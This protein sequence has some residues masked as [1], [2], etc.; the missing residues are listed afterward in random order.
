MASTGQVIAVNNGEYCGSIGDLND[1]FWRPSL[2][3]LGGETALLY[4]NH[5]GGD[6]TPTIA[7]LKY[8]TDNDKTWSWFGATPLVTLPDTGVPL[9][10]Y[11]FRWSPYGGVTKVGDERRLYVFYGV[12]LWE[13]YTE[14]SIDRWYLLDKGPVVNSGTLPEIKPTVF[15]QVSAGE[16]HACAI[17]PDNTVDCWGN[18]NYGQLNQPS[19]TFLQVSAG[20]WTTCG[21]KT[22]KSIACWGKNDYNLVSN[23]P[24]GYNF[25]QV[26]VGL[27]VACGLKDDNSVVCWGDSGDGRLTPQIGMTQISAGQWHTCGIK[28]NGTIYCWGDDGGTNRTKPPVLPAGTTWKQVSAAAWHT[29]G[30]R[31][32]GAAVCWGDNDENRVIPVPAL[33]AGLTYQEIS[34]GDWHTCALV[35]DGSIRCWG[36]DTDGRVSLTPTTGK[37]TKIEAGI[38]NT[39]A[40]RSDGGITCWGNNSQ[41]QSLP[42][43]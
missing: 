19:G 23:H 26:S 40:T 10:G 30:I 33:S 12:T 41:K 6:N 39:C 42:P 15:S 11:N 38:R 2:V 28:T 13:A 35:S 37:L 8:A 7:K 1:D 16:E 24:S 5:A 34:A 27:M 43:F 17:K 4:Q 18:N 3:D 22:D 20:N 25:K 36:D 21:V 29:C 9:T 14:E 32:D 31:S